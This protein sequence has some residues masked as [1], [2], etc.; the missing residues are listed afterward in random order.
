MLMIGDTTMKKMIALTALM[1]IAVCQS[2]SAAALGTGTITTAAGQVIRGGA[3]A[4]A[5][6]AATNPMGKMST[7][8]Y[9]GVAY[10]TTGYAIIT[11]HQTGSK[12]VGTA[13]DSTAIYFISEPAGVLTTAPSDAS[14]TAFATGWTSM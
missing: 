12:K 4:T 10:S 1:V 11:K 13:N 8:V 2:A 7:G 5:A 3:D 6:A 9:L 14:V